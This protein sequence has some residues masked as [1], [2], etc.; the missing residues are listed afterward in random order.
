MKTVFTFLVVNVIFFS[1]I[2][3][4]AINRQHANCNKQPHETFFEPYDLQD[5][6]NNLFG[7]TM[8]M[9][10]TINAW[11]NSLELKQS[12]DIV[13]TEYHDIDAWTKYY[14]NEYSYNQKGFNTQSIQHDLNEEESDLIPMYK[15]D[16]Y[17][18]DNRNVT[19]I[20]DS[21]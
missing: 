13:V 11:Q 15:N 19:S 12:L 21:R 20:N 18:D 7:L 1:T 9:P 3:Q 17:F 14:L 6:N 10:N 5:C 4:P 16:F 8:F 2:A